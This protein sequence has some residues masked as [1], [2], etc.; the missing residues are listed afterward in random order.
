MPL[1][2]P[3][4]FFFDHIPDRKFKVTLR[5]RKS[6]TSQNFTVE[7]N[8]LE[9]ILHLRNYVPDSVGFVGDYYTDDI[10]RIE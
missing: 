8:L 4:R 2:I 6:M 3:I 10:V 1:E 9:L 7:M 5:N